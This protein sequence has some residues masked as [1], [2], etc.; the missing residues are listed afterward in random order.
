MGNAKRMVKKFT[1]TLAE[2]N[3]MDQTNC[4]LSVHVKMK[5]TLTLTEKKKKRRYLLFTVQGTD[6]L[7]NERNSHQNQEIQSVLCWD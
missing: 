2:K 3:P 7:T 5:E 6:T 1:L 4:D